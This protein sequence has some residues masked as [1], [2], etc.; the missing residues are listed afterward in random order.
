MMPSYENSASDTPQNRRPTGLEPHFIPDFLQLRDY[1]TLFAIFTLLYLFKLSSFSISIDDEMAA[2]R[3]VADVWLRQGRWGVY[4]LERFIISQQ[5]VPFFPF[6]VF[7]CCLTISYR[8]LLTAFGAARVTFAHHLVFVLYVG[9]PTWMYAIAFFSNT[10]AFG[11]GQL[12]VVLAFAVARPVLEAAQPRMQLSLFAS[13]LV[14]SGLLAVSIGLYQS[15]L[16]EFGSL[17]TAYLVALLLKSDEGWPIFIRRLFALLGISLVSIL[18]YECANLTLLSLT[19]IQEQYVANFLNLG[20]LRSQ[21]LTVI[22][23]VATNFVATYGGGAIVFG[24]QL[25][26]FALVVACAFVSLALRMSNR[27]TA[28][29]IMLASAAS[30]CIPFVFHGLSGGNLP[31]RT[32][33]AV[34]VVMWFFAMIALSSDRQWLARLSLVAVLVA[35]LQIVY[36]LNLM[37]TA[38]EFARKHDEILAG[39][40]YARISEVAPPAAAAQPFLVDFYGGQKFDGVYPRSEQ[41]TQGYSFFEWDGGNIFRITAYMRLLG[42]SQLRIPDPPARHA[43]DAEFQ[44]MPVWPAPGSVRWANGM[45]L[46]RLGEAPG[47]R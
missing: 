26:S 8:V 44:R 37:Q 46:V 31:A 40:V 29:K 4:L 6:F 27:G 38:N 25:H 20:A 23:A 16:L 12:T 30:I 11:L 5:V 15:F 45:A 13:C 42:Y 17:G 3:D 9:F 36:A 10:I 14:A 32:L 39:A 19:H 41:A 35:S 2:V 34:P 28:L 24:A 22:G 1:V 18:L 7:G 47:F 43:N 21:P 33:V